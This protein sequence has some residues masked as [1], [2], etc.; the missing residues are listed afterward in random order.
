MRL[1][2]PGRVNHPTADGQKF[3]GPFCDSVLDAV[4]VGR[5]GGVPFLAA[6]KIVVDTKVSGRNRLNI[7]PPVSCTLNIA[8]F[9][10]E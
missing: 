7:F 1:P 3:D 6:D 8:M 4:K 9:L 2:A 10:E 5:V